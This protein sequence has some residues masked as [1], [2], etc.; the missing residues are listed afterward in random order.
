VSNDAR[1][2]LL[3]TPRFEVIRTEAR[4]KSFYYVEKPD[5]VVILAKD[6]DRLWLVNTLRLNVHGRSLE[7]PGGRVEAGETALEAA[8]RELV[9]ETGL[10]ASEWQLLGSVLPL[11]SVTTERVH[12]FAANVVG[13]ANPTLQNTDEIDCALITMS[14]E[15]A[16]AAAASG[17]VTCAVDAFAI[18]L[19]ERIQRGS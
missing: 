9:E 2:I 10:N 17:S 3:S 15:E 14:L 4:G 12:I 11:P 7:L 13:T 19:L 18:L 1:V 6:V 8:K 5:A 16:A